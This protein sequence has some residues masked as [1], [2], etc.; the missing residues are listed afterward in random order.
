[1]FWFSGAAFREGIDDHTVDGMTVRIYGPEKTVADCFKF[2]NKL[3]LDVALEALRLWRRQ[4]GARADDLLRYA[5]IVR[6][7]RIIRPYLEA[8]S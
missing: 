5:R 3:G 8:L 4:P 2:R 6:V 7:E 1:V